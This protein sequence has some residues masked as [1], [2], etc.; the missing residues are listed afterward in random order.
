NSRMA[1][2]KQPKASL[3]AHKERAKRRSAKRKA[4]AIFRRRRHQP[5]RPPL[6]KIRPGSPAPAMGAGTPTDGVIGG[7]IGL[8]AGGAGD[9]PIVQGPGLL[10][11][12][13]SMPGLPDNAM[14]IPSDDEV[15]SE[16]MQWDQLSKIGLVLEV[17][18][19]QPMM[20]PELRMK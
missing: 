6:A 8:G 17:G 4:Q 15:G 14:K 3:E 7:S 9:G 1:A 2:L 10:K 11:L 12:V 5:R 18:N 16:Q 20:A 13:A 19:C